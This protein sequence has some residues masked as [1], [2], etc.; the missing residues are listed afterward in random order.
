VLPKFPALPDYM[1]KVDLTVF[2]G[3]VRAGVKHEVVS[4]VTVSETGGDPVVSLDRQ[5][6]SKGFW[7]IQVGIDGRYMLTEHMGVGM[8]LRYAGASGDV[9]Q[10]LNLDLGG[11]QIGG[12]A[13]L[14]F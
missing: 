9:T 2:A 11:F 1:D 5:T 6:I 12:G 10:G 4:A 3:P 8:F 7:G 14:K 13:R